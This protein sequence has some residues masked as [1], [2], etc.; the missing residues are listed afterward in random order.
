[1]QAA[2]IAQG[3]EVMAYSSYGAFVYRNGERRTDKE[4]VG[5]YD[6]DEG[7]LPSGDR[8]FMNI[9]KNR[10]RG[11][12][13][14]WLHSHHG[15]MGDGPVRVACYKQGLPSGGIYT[16]EEGASEPRRITPQELSSNP[17]MPR[18]LKD[19]N[20]DPDA[21]DAYIKSLYDYEYG[22]FDVTYGEYRFSFTD[23]DHSES[24]HYEATMIEPDGTEWKC[25]YD[26]EYGAGHTD[27]SPLDAERG[28]DATLTRVIAATFGEEES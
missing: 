24:G 1:L 20:E 11:T 4:D 21:W 28:K 27:V 26:Y 14:W 5:V 25:V 13:D 18:P 2:S 22:H 23:D 7:N 3:N 17:P 9:L 12:N 6:T 19:Y 10:E 15:V 16:W 8:I